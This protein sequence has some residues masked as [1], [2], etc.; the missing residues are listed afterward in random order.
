MLKRMIG[1]YYLKIKGDYYIMENNITDINTFLI[2]KCGIQSD[3]LIDDIIDDKLQEKNNEGQKNLLSFDNNKESINY[4]N[5]N[6]FLIFH[7]LQNITINDVNQDKHNISKTNIENWINITNKKEKNLL[8]NQHNHK[9][10]LK[11]NKEKLLELNKRKEENK[12]IM[13]EME[14]INT[15]NEDTFESETFHN[16]LDIIKTNIKSINSETESIQQEIK[17]I[18]IENK[19]NIKDID[20]YKNILNIIKEIEKNIDNYQLFLKTIEKYKNGKYKSFSNIADYSF[21]IGVSIIL[22]CILIN[23]FF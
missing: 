1:K 8:L 2:N 22:F 17:Q 6:I 20:K 9:I 21:F 15:L 14:S 3:K 10:F 4:I 18:T 19:E 13:K 5:C 16:K 23:L 11:E 7:L 12:I